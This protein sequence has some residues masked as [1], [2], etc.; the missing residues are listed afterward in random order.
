TWLL[1]L[2]LL[3]PMVKRRQNTYNQQE[4]YVAFSGFALVQARPIPAWLPCQFPRDTAGCRYQQGF[5]KG[6][7]M[8]RHIALAALAVSSLTA[9]QNM[10]MA[11][12]VGA[13]S[14]LF[15]AATVSDEQIQELAVSSQ[16][17][18]D[19]QNKI[20]SANS[21]YTTRLARVT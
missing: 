1:G 17:Q 2:L 6:K 10:D 3:S 4:F 8:F 20:A 5:I 15:Q 14:S 9:C 7:Y 21:K 12:M 19:S 16:Q 13:A 11:G 18:L